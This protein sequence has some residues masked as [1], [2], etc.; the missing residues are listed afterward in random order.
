MESRYM[1]LL[2]H[3]MQDSNLEQEKEKEKDGA[4]VATVIAAYT[5]GA[6]ILSNDYLLS[7]ITP[8]IYKE[9]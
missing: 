7:I 2:C 5:S 8:Y 3:V 1:L 4:T 9:I 6:L